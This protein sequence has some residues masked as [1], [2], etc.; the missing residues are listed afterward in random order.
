[1]AWASNEPRFPPLDD[2]QNPP[3]PLPLSPACTVALVRAPPDSAV[4]RRRRRR[5]R[6]RRQFPLTCYAVGGTEADNP[7]NNKLIL[8]R[9]SQLHR[10]KHDDDKESDSDGSPPP[11]PSPAAPRRPSPAPRRPSPPAQGTGAEGRCC[12]LWGRSPS[13]PRAPP[14]PLRVGCAS[15]SVAAR[16]GPSRGP[17][18]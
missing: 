4:A 18:V 6:R 11:R 15:G 12:A 5:R 10:T 3:S 9:M 1:M 14:T 7:K 13:P 2:V 8:M 17:E 16:R